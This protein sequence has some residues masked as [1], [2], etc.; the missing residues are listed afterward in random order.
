MLAR[1]LRFVH[2]A[3]NGNR[4]TNSEVAPTAARA[5]SWSGAQLAARKKCRRNTI[6]STSV[7]SF[8]RAK[9]SSARHVA[10]QEEQP[11]KPRIKHIERR[12]S[13]SNKLAVSAE[14]FETRKPFDVSRAGARTCVE[15]ASRYGALHA[16]PCCPS[17]TSPL[18]MFLIFLRTIDR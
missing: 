17:T 10:K 12:S 15:S 9:M 2:A 5:A 16:L 4:R 13:R 3:R 18:K 7:T 8:L 14:Y 6:H 1:R 11:K